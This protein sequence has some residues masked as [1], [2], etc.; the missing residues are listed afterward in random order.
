MFNDHRLHCSPELINDEYFLFEI[1]NLRSSD[2]D[3][4]IHEAMQIWTHL[5]GSVRGR[6]TGFVRLGQQR[7]RQ[8]GSFVGFKEKRQEEVATMVKAL[9]GFWLQC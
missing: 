3:A 4:F 7:K 5:Y 8:E 2:V 6:K 9:G 1:A